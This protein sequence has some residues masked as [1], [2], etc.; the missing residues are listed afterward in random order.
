[1]RV[2]RDPCLKVGG[3]WIPYFVGIQTCD[4]AKRSEISLFVDRCSGCDCVE[5]HKPEFVS[6]TWRFVIFS[7]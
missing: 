4:K 1:M 6:Q 5:S 3:H 2:N 7:D